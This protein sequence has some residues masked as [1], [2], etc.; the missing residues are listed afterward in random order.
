MKSFQI[1]ETAKNHRIIVAHRGSA[2]G[3]VPPNTRTAYEAALK[4]GAD[5]IETDV[6]RTKDGVLVIN[7]PQLEP[8]HLGQP[9]DSIRNSTYE[10]IRAF[11]HVNYDHAPTELGV[12]TFDELLEA[13][14]GRCYINVDKFW[15]NPEEI[16]RAIKAHGME[17]QIV[18]KSGLKPEVLA[19]MKN[20][21]PE[22]AFMPIVSETFPE[23]EELM[24]S[25]IHYIGAEVLFSRDDSE[26]ATP[27]FIE[28]MHRDGKLVWANAIIYD[29]RAQLSAGHSDDAS[30]AGEMK[31]G[32]GWLAQRGFDFI[33]TDWAGML[34][35]YLK[36]TG[37]YYKN[38]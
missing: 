19:V 28:K 2:A 35:S 37:K 27:E 26:V 10:E 14:K 31:D 5:M 34:I 16:Y 8:C 36:E 7:H 15:D 9:R 30:L 21:C 23:H 33:Q 3:N 18:V 13:Y 12:L 29:C 6:N 11:R 22:L 32:W 20:L 24:K 25:G 38:K 1:F 4:Q 17:D